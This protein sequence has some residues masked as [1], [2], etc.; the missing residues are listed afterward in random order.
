MP[1]QHKKS[2]VTGPAFLFPAVWKYI[3][4][5]FQCGGPLQDIRSVK[6]VCEVLEEV[7]LVQSA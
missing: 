1:Y 3:S 2:R 5:R 4:V 6:Y 7:Y